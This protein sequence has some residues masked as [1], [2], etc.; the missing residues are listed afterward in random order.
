MPWIPGQTTQRCWKEILDKNPAII[1]YVYLGD[2][3]LGLMPT[4][5]HSGALV[6][7]ARRVARLQIMAL[8]ERLA[9]IVNGRVSDGMFRLDVG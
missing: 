4:S 1:E 9:G 3:C 5:A 6:P 2:S 8:A 7:T